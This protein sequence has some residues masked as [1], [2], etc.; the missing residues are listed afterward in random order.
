MAG[1]AFMHARYLQIWVTALFV[2]VGPVSSAHSRDADARLIALYTTEWQW[3]EQQL[4]DSEDSQ[5]PIMDHLAKVDPAAQQL[6]LH[7]WEEVQRRLDGINRAELS[8]MQQLNYDVY[9]PQ[10]K[11]LI[12][13][14]RFRDFEMPANS[15][16]AF[17]TD[18]DIRRGECFASPKST[19]T[20]SA[21]WRDVP[22]YFR[23]QMQQMR[24]GRRAALRLPPSP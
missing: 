7:Y 20:G 6:R 14:Q 4:P 10:I 2:T 1:E 13:N 8:S 5:R 15:D 24:A 21:R 12:A 19:A 16:S 9:R 18:L 11:V 22:R 3:R 17:W 23:E